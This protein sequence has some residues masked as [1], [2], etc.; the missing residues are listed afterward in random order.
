MTYLQSYIQQRA[1]ARGYS[2]WS[3]FEEIAGFFDH[4]GTRAKELI[5]VTNA[6]P[7]NSHM[8][9]WSQAELQTLELIKV[10]HYQGQDSA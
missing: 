9:K 7:G 8:S 5:I 3:I 4:T 1:K 2:F 10:K 6:V